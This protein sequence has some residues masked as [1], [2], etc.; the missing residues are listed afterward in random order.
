MSGLEIAALAM[1]VIAAVRALPEIPKVWH[2]VMRVSLGD[3]PFPLQIVI[4]LL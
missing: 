3:V 4:D 2:K 1:A